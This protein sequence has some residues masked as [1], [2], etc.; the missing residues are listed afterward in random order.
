M[1]IL[2]CKTTV[3]VLPATHCETEN[4]IKSHTLVLFTGIH[5]NRARAKLCPMVVLLAER[6]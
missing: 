2:Y 3:C 6:Y 5:T 4:G 1:L